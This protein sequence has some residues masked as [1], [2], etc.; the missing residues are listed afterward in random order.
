MLQDLA[1]GRRTEIDFLN[2]AIAAF[3]ARHGIPAPLNTCIA[4]LVRFRESLTNG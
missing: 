1:R 3:A 2:G 4:N